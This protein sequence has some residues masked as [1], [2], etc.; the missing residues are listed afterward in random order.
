[1]Y[2]RHGVA[3]QP[4]N[5]A[6][7]ESS[8][9]NAIGLGDMNSIDENRSSRSGSTSRTQAERPSTGAGQQNGHGPVIAV[10]PN[11]S[12]ESPTYRENP[13]VHLDVG[14]DEGRLVQ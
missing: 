5:S 14:Y 3:A 4:Q 7:E 6:E 2:R 10:N 12:A 11:A 9:G 8:D 13:I 1:M